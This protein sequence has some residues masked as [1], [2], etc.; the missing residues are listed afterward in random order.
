MNRTRD[1]ETVKALIKVL[2][3]SFVG[4][5]IGAGWV[6]YAAIQHG[7]SGYFWLPLSAMG[8]MTACLI[9]LALYRPFVRA[10]VSN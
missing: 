6:A 4:S 7:A 5:F 8:A 3:S 10:R 9:M 1:L 2:L